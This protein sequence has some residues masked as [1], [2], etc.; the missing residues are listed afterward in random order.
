[1][2]PTSTIDDRDYRRTLAVLERG[3]NPRP[4]HGFRGKVVFLGNPLEI[5]QRQR[6]I[7][8][9]KRKV[10]CWRVLQTVDRNLN[11]IDSTLVPI[12]IHVTF[13]AVSGG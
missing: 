8:V 3:G 5:E 6:T 9:L 10:T 1:M 13:D 11:R 4:V 2:P 12:S 7:V